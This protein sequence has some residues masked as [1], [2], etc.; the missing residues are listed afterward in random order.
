MICQTKVGNR[1]HSIEARLVLRVHLKMPSHK[2]SVRHRAANGKYLETIPA[3]LETGAARSVAEWARRSRISRSEALRRLINLGLAAVA[4]HK[5]AATASGVVAHQIE[6]LS[7][8]AMPE[9]EQ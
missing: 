7:D 3:R 1:F 4:S 5:G 6:G 8:L 9:E 2:R